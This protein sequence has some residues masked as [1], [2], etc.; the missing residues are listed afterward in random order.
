MANHKKNRYTQKAHKTAII[1]SFQS[2]LETKGNIKNSLLETGKDLLIGVLGGGIVGAAIGKPSLLIGLGVTGLGHYT[3]NRL[4]TLLGVGLMASNGFQTKSTV[5]GLDGMDGIKDRLQAYKDSFAQKLYL[6]KVLKKKAEGVNGMGQLQ[7]FNYGDYNPQLT[8]ESYYSNDL[9][10]GL[11]ALDNIQQQIE[12]AGMARLQM[13]DR[14]FDLEG[15]D[16][17]EGIGMADVTDYNL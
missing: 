7:Y 8:G 17:F 12:D 15:S 6:D 3:D 5:A 11:A 9:N 10:G 4:A 13:G 1:G 16:D 14:Q 2:K